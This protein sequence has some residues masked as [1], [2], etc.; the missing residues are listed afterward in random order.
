MRINTDGNGFLIG[1]NASLTVKGRPE[2]N[3]QLSIYLLTRVGTEVA[4][5]LEPTDEIASLRRAASFL[6]DKDGFDEIWLGGHTKLDNQQFHVTQAFL[7]WSRE[8]DAV[9]ATPA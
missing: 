2:A 4:S 1:Q 5:L 3:H 8:H 6:K 9:K 7:L